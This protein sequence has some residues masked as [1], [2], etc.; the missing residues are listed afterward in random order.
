MER[1]AQLGRITDQRQQL[2][3]AGGA[4]AAHPVTEAQQMAALVTWPGP[5]TL[6]QYSRTTA[7][8]AWCALELIEAGEPITVVCSRAHAARSWIFLRLA[9]RDLGRRHRLRF[10][11]AP[12]PSWH[13]WLYELRWLHHI[14]RNCRSAKERREQMLT[15]L[16]RAVG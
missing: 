1:L 16:A 4:K 12:S 9:M 11:I 15:E 7:E 3:L 13:A 8:N 5:I 14:A 2:V 6:E 10:L